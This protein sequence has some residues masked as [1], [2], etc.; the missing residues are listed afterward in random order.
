LEQHEGWRV[1]AEASRGHDA[2]RLARETKPDVAVL[3]YALPQLDGVML[4]RAIKRDL[5][6]T[7]VLIYSMHSQENIITDALRAGARGYVLKSDPA[8]HL[9]AA[10]EALIKHK[11]Y[12]SPL[13]AETVLEQFNQ[14]KDPAQ[15][16]VLTPREREVVQ[17]IA[18]GKINKQVAHTLDIT[19]KTVET[20]RA[21]VMNKLKLRTTADL[22]R[23]AVRNQIVMP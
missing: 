19:V 18:E 12:Y 11:P 7:E 8:P 3:A 6:G 17:L 13:I 23:Y 21:A 15:G 9:I 2:L 14:R 1:V 5:P 20:H 16:I 4:T 22:V 10:I